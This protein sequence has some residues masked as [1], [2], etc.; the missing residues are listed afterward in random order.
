MFFFSLPIN[1][2]CSEDTHLSVETAVTKL[3]SSSFY[4]YNIFISAVRIENFYKCV[5]KNII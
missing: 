3:K 2:N 4:V 1:L 5:K